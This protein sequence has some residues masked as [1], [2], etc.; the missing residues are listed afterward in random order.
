MRPEQCLRCFS[1]SEKPPVDEK[2]SAR[3]ETET[4]E[5]RSL[6]QSRSA[7]TAKTATH[8]MKDVT[9]KGVLSVSGFR[10][11]RYA[12]RPIRRSTLCDSCMNIFR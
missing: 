2:V 12:H 10:S 8:W 3:G 4:I 11:K 5:A 1:W 6:R 7:K 9:S